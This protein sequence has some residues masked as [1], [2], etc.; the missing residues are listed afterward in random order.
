MH[1]RCSEITRVTS[2]RNRGRQF[3]LLSTIARCLIHGIMPRSFSP[4]SSIGCD[5]IL[6]R[7]ALNEV[8]LTRFSSIQ[9]RVKVP[10]WMSERIFFISALVASLTTRG[11]ETYS[12]YSAVLDTE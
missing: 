1:P 6:A 12:P 2:H 8:W 9:L 11:P 10:V 4:T 7:M 3:L 5:A